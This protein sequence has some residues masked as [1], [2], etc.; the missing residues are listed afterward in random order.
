MKEQANE[1]NRE[2]GV[3]VFLG[4]SQS[5]QQNREYLDLAAAIGYTRLF[6]SLH[7]PEGN[8][9]EIRQQVAKLL[10]Y[11]NNRGFT[12]TADI[13]PR[14]QDGLG[15]ETEKLF[16]MGV[17]VVRLDYGYGHAQIRQLLEE[18]DLLVEV[19]ASTLGVEEIDSLLAIGIDRSRLRAG[20]NYYPRP[21]TGMGMALFRQRSE[22]FCRKGI[23]V[24]AFI[25]GLE[26]A[27]GPIGSGLPTLESHRRLDSVLAARQMWA[28]NCLQSLFF[29]DP[30][31]SAETLQAVRNIS[32]FPSVP[33][34]LHVVPDSSLT[35][36]MDALLFGCHQNRMDAAA[37]VIRSAHSRQKTSCLVP[38][39]VIAPR[40]RGDITIDNFQYGRYMGEVQIVLKD[41]PGDER[42]NVIARVAD[43]DECLLDCIG[44]GQE[45]VLR[46]VDS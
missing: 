35:E 7:I 12:V 37:V 34:V 41:M 1:M 23:P 24:S 9:N 21:D 38:S 30:L 4:M 6:T 20:H 40:K 22:A 26:S 10:D 13:S 31:I 2:L 3:S 42:V 19:N 27:R 15:I 25:P 36:E 28:V 32:A 17:H 45:F 33:I 43:S 39:G 11:A 29:S 46:R 18:T 5:E 8:T 16:S 14:T 44:P